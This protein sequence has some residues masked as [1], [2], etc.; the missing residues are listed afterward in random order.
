MRAKYIDELPADQSDGVLLD[1]YVR[2]ARDLYEGSLDA[3]DLALVGAYVTAVHDEIVR[4][5]RS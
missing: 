4:R 1:E 5:M 3:K 2:C